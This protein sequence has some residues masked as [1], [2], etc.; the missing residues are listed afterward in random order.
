[1]RL[2]H[3]RL[4]VSDHDA[5][6]RF[7]RDTLGFEIILGQEGGVYSELRVGEGI[8]LG[9]Y[10]RQ[11]MADIVG[12]GDLPP[13]APVQDPVILTFDVADV[14]AT[15]QQLRERGVEW[16]VPPQ[17]RREWFLRTA[18]FRDPDGNLIEI[19]HSLASR[20]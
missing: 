8:I 3:V 20:Q 13:Y 7:Y 10:G 4:L 9:L 16:V 12:T 17:D 1:M 5:S 2:T 15:Y 11:M 6:L 18:H 19:N 14:D